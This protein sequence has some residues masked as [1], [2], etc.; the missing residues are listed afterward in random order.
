MKSWLRIVPPLAVVG[1]ATAVCIW[2]FATK[3]EPRKWPQR[4][5][6]PEVAVER[7]VPVDYQVWLESQGTVQA[8]TESTLI[9]EVSGR[10]LEVSPKFRDGAFFEKGDVLLELDPRDYETAY[11]VAQAALAQA[12]LELEQEQAAYEIAQLDFE[13]ALITE[14]PTPIALREPQLK[15]ARANV[16]SAKARL[17]QARNNL[18]DTRIVAPYAGRVLRQNV[19]VG[20]FVTPGTVLARLYAVDYAEVRLPLTERQMQFMDLKESFRGE[21]NPIQEFPRVILTWELGQQQFEWEGRIVRS[22]GAID[23]GSRQLFVVAQVDDPYGKGQGEMPLKVGSF[24]E[25]KIEGRTLPRRFIIPRKMY[26]KNEYVLIVNHDNTLERRG[27]T[28]EWSTEDHLVVSEGIRPGEMLCRT[29]INFPVNG[30]RVNVVEVDGESRRKE[31]DW[32]KVP[33]E[34]KQ[35]FEQAR[36]D[37][38]WQKMRQLQTQLEAY[39]VE[40]SAQGKSSPSKTQG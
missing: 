29:Q 32:E 24:V 35:E 3:P 26:R 33:P 12:E 30:M 34:L 11:I 39:K 23:T 1:L 16:E 27:L 31:I 25:A 5:T 22:E 8:R 15:L 9:P 14:D 20:Q 18:D 28:V 17:E 40:V 19:D 36:A 4:E 6:I 2:L 7:L 13:S 38:N 10:I 37:Q 21:E